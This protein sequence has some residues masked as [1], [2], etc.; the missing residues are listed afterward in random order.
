M[1]RLVIPLSR[2]KLALLLLIACLFVVAGWWMF[3]LDAAQ[4]AAQR[5]YNNP[6]FVHG[7]GLL[8]L[9]F[10]ALGA[11]A[12]A[13]KLFDTSPGLILDERGLTDNASAMSAGFIPWSDITGIQVQQIH[14]QRLLNVVLADPEAYLARCKPWKRL[15]LRGNL[16]MGASPVAIP[17]STLAIGFD[18]LVERVEE[19][20]A[21]Q[22]PG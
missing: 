16:R 3:D 18:E 17:S 19:H 15:L 6:L 2:T 10:G 4:I 5:R 7:I 1:R 11:V 13:R 21:A 9:V 20:L 12:I 8:G 14:R 22:R